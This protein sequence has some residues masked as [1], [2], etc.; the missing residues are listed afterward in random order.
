MADIGFCHRRLRYINTTDLEQSV[1]NEQEEIPLAF[2]QDPVPAERDHA[3][4]ELNF[5]PTVP[6]RLVDE[7]AYGE[8]TLLGGPNYSRRRL[9]PLLLTNWQFRQSVEGFHFDAQRVF[10]DESTAPRA[11]RVLQQ[12]VP[13]EPIILVFDC[14]LAYVVREIS[15]CSH[16][17]ISVLRRLVL[18]EGFSLVGSE[19]MY[20]YWTRP[21]EVPSQSARR[22]GPRGGH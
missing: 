7:G 8:L 6:G 17:P 22:R 13:H 18:I 5:G 10:I 11:E 1:T 15:V 14:E 3:P 9:P 2:A 20:R 12:I 21:P 4:A 19:L 16:G